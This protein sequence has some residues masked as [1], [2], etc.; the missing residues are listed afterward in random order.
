MTDVAQ[1]TEDGAYEGTLG[2]RSSWFLISVVCINAVLLLVAA[3][4]ATAPQFPLS[5]SNLFAWLLLLVIFPIAIRVRVAVVGRAKDDRELERG[6]SSRKSR[7][8]SVC[9]IALGVLICL[10]GWTFAHSGALGVALDH[11]VF[12]DSAGSFYSWDSTGA[13]IPAT[14]TEHSDYLRQY[15]FTPLA[16]AIVLGGFAQIY[17]GTDE[18]APGLIPEF[19]FFPISSRFGRNRRLQD[20]WDVQ[21]DDPW[22]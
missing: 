7:I 3:L 5:V 22:A 1:V 20:R 10:F 13:R 17:A 9:A 16:V 2:R 19:L 14:A 12:M 4:F 15:A 8:I 18:L 6:A 11:R 21:P